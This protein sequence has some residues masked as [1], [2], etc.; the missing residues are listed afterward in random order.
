MYRSLPQR[1]T[2]GVD[3]FA[4]VARG[5][6]PVCRLEEPAVRDRSDYTFKDWLLHICLPDG[7]V[8]YRIGALRPD[9]IVYDATW[10][11]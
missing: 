4:K 9:G 2:F 10:P 8:I 11:D 5:E 7:H 1:T 3:F 6:L